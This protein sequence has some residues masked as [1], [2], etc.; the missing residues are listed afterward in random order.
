MVGARGY[1]YDKGICFSHTKAG[2]KEAGE[3][4]QDVLT[5]SCLLKTSF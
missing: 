5:P 3:V 1:V 4:E 2:D